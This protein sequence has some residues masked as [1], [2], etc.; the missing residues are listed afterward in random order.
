MNENDPARRLVTDVLGREPTDEEILV[1]IRSLE[2]LAY[3]ERRVLELVYGLG[4]YR[5][6]TL[7]EVGRTFNATRER[8]L[9]IET[10]SATEAE[11]SRVAR[12]VAAQRGT[13][14]AS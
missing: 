10:Q 14:A 5:P 11:A 1:V 12:S 3:R 6:R 8:I 9:Q 2:T 13:A 7:D 4:D